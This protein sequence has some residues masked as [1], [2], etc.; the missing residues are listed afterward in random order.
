[1]E[2]R[3]PIPVHPD[4]LLRAEDALSAMCSW[5]LDANAWRE[6]KT[7]RQSMEWTA[8]Y[9][10]AQEVLRQIAA[11]KRVCGIED[12]GSGDRAAELANVLPPSPTSPSPARVTP[13]R[14]HTHTWRW[15]PGGDYCDGCER[16]RRE[17]EGQPPKPRDRAAEHRRAGVEMM[18]DGERLLR[19]QA[20]LP[21]S[22]L[23]RPMTHEMQSGTIA[24]DEGKRLVWHS[25]KQG[26]TRCGDPI[27]RL[28]LARGIYHNITPNLYLY[29]KRRQLQ[30]PEDACQACLC[31]ELAFLMHMGRMTSGEARTILG[32]DVIPMPHA[33]VD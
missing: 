18:A 5:A 2:T 7:D 19:E 11:L 29:E 25:V 4:W 26:Y 10:G 21:P 28:G 33:P 31:D 17:V 22:R 6:G 20:D 32:V 23:L 9:A 1:M 14:P 8:E 12:A 27:T 15:S 16:W 13:G 30:H 24:S 3:R